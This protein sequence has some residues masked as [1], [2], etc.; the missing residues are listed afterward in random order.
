MELG[1]APWLNPEL[2]AVLLG[3]FRGDANAAAGA[4]M[5]SDGPALKAQLKQSTKQAEV[6]A[7]GGGGAAGG[8]GGGQRKGGQHQCR[9][10]GS[11]P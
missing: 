10:R 2:E 8:T 11:R 3:E 6:A 4:S 5:S 1:V 7:G 9:G